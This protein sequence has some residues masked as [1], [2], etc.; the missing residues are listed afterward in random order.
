MTTIFVEDR[1]IHSPAKCGRCGSVRYD[2][3]KYVQFGMD[4][5]FYGIVYLCS[6]CVREIYKAVFNGNDGLPVAQLESDLADALQT[7]ELQQTLL[8][9]RE[10]QIETLENTYGVV[11]PDSSPVAESSDSPPVAESTDSGT[12]T[13]NSKSSGRKKPVTKSVTSSRPKNVPSLTELLEPTSKS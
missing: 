7:I 13:G 11:E 9:T 4:I 3:R 6:H 2:G 10:E 5:E 8:N 12:K 1:P